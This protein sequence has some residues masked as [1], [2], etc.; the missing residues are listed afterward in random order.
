ME[1]SKEK[2]ESFGWESDEFLDLSEFLKPLDGIIDQATVL[3]IEEIKYHGWRGVRSCGDA[4][5]VKNEV[6]FAMEDWAKT[7]IYENRHLRYIRYGHLGGSYVITNSGG[8]IEPRKCSGRL[9]LKCFIE[10]QTI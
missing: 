2:S 7:K 4:D 9:E 8:G 10:F 1:V 6:N 5:R 3:R